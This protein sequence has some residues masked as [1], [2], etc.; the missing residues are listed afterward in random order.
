MLARKSRKNFIEN[1]TEENNLL[2]AAGYIRLSVNKADQPSDS[3]ENQ[4]KII[5]GYSE[6]NFDLQLEKFYID[7]KASGRDFNRPA[8]N[9]MIEDI[10]AGKINCVIVKDLSRLGRS[11]IDVGYYVQM[12]FPGQ[13][14]RFISIANGIDTL[15]G[16]RNIIFGKLPGD[17][18]SLTSLMDEQYAI[19]ISK[20]TQSV[21]KNYIEEGKH[22]APRAPY[23]YRK[24]DCDYHTLVPDAESAIVVKKIFSM[25]FVRISINEI[26]RQLNAKGIPTPISYAVSQGLKGNY[27][28]GNGLWNS[29]TVKDI[30]L[31]RTYV[32]DL[33]QGKDKHVVQDTHEPLVCRDVFDVVQQ[34]IS[35]GASISPNKT[36]APCEDNILRGK[37][38]C[39]CCG[40]K[41]Q[42]RKGSGNA[43]WHFFTCISNNRLGAGH[44]TGM[45]IRESDIM[46]AIFREVKSYIHDNEAAFITYVDRKSVL[47]VNE[48]QLARQINEQREVSRSRYENF[49]R[50]IVDKEDYTF[51]RNKRETLHTELQ[52]I[53]NQIKWQNEKY[54]QYLLFC[55]AL[56]DKEKIGQLVADC[57]LN[58]SVLANGQINVK[59]RD[60]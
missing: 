43:N 35:E 13:K 40:R 2:R 58:V 1:K 39:G 46:D 51:E 47:E 30:L 41:M 16:M 20:K 36:N 18:I 27:N 55:N 15:D 50:G 32:G 5:G 21:L 10:R 33:E 11:L 45:Y 26:V 3:I 28:R 7:D 44:C 49:I 6:T 29:R 60:S 48:K 24:S 42:R 54:E 9:E 59:W 4:K 38:I 31:N 8:F 37:V 22:V 12:F 53:N 17:H 52:N 57:I 14:I 25:A 34:L 19:D 56:N 23:G